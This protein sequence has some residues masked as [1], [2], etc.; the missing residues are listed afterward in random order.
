MPD[1][2]RIR[3]RILERYSIRGRVSRLTP[4]GQGR[5]GVA[6]VE[7][8]A[9]R[10]GQGRE[11]L[12]PAA[13]WVGTPGEG[14]EVT[15]VWLVSRGRGSGPYVALQNHTRSETRYN[16]RA[17]ARLYRPDRFMIAAGVLVLAVAPL[18][19][20]VAF[21]LVLAVAGSLYGILGRAGLKAD[22]RLLGPVRGREA[23]AGRQHSSTTSQGTV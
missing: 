20:G 23:G 4:P 12:L 18:A 11:P 7:R 3:G 1:Q 19:I 5:T 6:A 15:A 21:A 17:L 22:G 10:D 2:I 9:I 13:A 14:D 16:D 8:L